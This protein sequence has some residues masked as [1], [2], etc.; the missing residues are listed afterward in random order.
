VVIGFAY[1]RPAAGGAAIVRRYHSF[2]GQLRS[3][4]ARL[5]I[6]PDEMTF[7]DYANIVSEWLAAQPRA[8][9]IGPI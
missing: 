1:A 2:R 4:L 3:I 8:T 6:E 5:Q 9:S 7:A